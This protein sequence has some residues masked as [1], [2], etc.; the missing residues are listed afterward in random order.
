LNHG[1][2]LM[3][4]MSTM[5]WITLIPNTIHESL[6]KYMFTT[7]KCKQFTIYT[8]VELSVLFFILFQLY[9]S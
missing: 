2:L 6:T 9:A 3:R 8:T 4:I 7:F 1:G 5:L